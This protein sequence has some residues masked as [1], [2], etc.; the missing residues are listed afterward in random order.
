MHGVRDVY[1]DAQGQLRLSSRKKREILIN[2]IYGVDIDPQAVEVTQMSLY[3]KVLEDENDATLNKPT[4]LALHEVLLPPLKNNIKCGNSLIGTDFYVQGELFDEDMRRKVNAFDWEMEFPFLKSHSDPARRAGEES[5]SFRKRDSSSRLKSVGT[6]NDNRGGFDVVIGNPPYLASYSRESVQ[7]NE[8]EKRYFARKYSTVTGRIN[9]FVMFVEKGMGILSSIGRLGFILPKP[10]LMMTAYHRMRTA[11]L[12][13]NI[14]KIALCGEEVFPDATVPSCILIASREDGQDQAKIE[15]HKYNRESELSLFKVISKRDVVN[16]PEHRI[17]AEVK[18]RASKVVF[19][20]S[21][22]GTPLGG[23][24]KVEDGINPGP[25]RSI[26][27]APKR[28]NNKCVKLIEGKDFSRYSPVAWGG[29]YFLWDKSLVKRLQPKHPNSVAVLGKEERFLQKEKI[30]TRQTAAGILA[31]LD[32]NQY[33]STNSVHTTRLIETEHPLDIRFVLG[34]LNSS[35][36]NFYYRQSF[37]EK[38]GSFPQV[39]VNKLRKLPMRT[40]D[41]TN[42]AE[43]QMHDELF[44]LVNRMLELHKQLQGHMEPTSK[45][46]SISRGLFASEREPIERQIAATDK[47]IDLLV[48]KLYGLTQGEIKI[49]EEAGR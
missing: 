11:L 39:K 2:N 23:L 31:A 12:R 35:L 30:V 42:P 25:F 36:M 46:D 45:V 7:M 28:Q 41:F 32:T 49:L 5:D 20:V 4:M 48:Y 10:F 40:I 44:A 6:Q 33:F 29:L 34:I 17:N 47:K 8:I 1:E 26:L 9:T 21:R 22:T 38:E 16:D 3:L 43:K 13:Q 24:A 15:I 18:E 27:V 19:K 14:E 37:K